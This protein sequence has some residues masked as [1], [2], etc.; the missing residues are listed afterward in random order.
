MFDGG[1]ADDLSEALDRSPLD[2]AQAA[3]SGHYTGSLAGAFAAFGSFEG[4]RV[5]ITATLSFDLAPSTGGQPQAILSG[6]V[7]G[8]AGGEI[9]LSCTIAGNVGGSPL[10]VESGASIG[11]TYCPGISDAE[12][13]CTAPGGSFRG[14][15]QGTYD[16]ATRAFVN[17]TWDGTSFV[18]GV[19]GGLVNS[20]CNPTQATSYHGCGTWSARLTP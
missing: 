2:N 9:S 10:E 19:P 20:G 6:S 3:Q 8:T 5:P 14:P 13:P 1:E 17:G 16:S 15:F 12:P 11:C 4:S 18:N 7:V